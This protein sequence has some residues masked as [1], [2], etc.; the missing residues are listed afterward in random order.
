MCQWKLLLPS[1][2][3][4]GTYRALGVVS[5]NI[6]KFCTRLEGISSTP[7][8][9]YM[10]MN[11]RLALS[12]T[13]HT[14]TVILRTQLRR[15]RTRHVR[16]ICSGKV[17]FSYLSIGVSHEKWPYYTFWAVSLI[18][19]AWC[20]VINS[21]ETIPKHWRLSEND[22]A[23]RINGLRVFLTT[24]VQR[25]YT[26]FASHHTAPIKIFITI[27]V[28][29]LYDSNTRNSPKIAWS[30]DHTSRETSLGSLDIGCNTPIK[31][32]ETRSDWVYWG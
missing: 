9:F 24:Q 12:V 15:S 28:S 29:M 8:N 3:W 13:M 23:G 21:M 5:G 27:K 11:N 30:G 2:D 1:G 17:H 31:S 10:L 19:S 32:A 7:P 26:S 14:P 22:H 20:G 16:H 18:S 4:C 25:Q 6:P